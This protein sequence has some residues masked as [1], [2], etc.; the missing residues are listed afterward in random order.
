MPVAIAMPKLGL[1]M[2]EGT[3]L[4]WHAELGERVEKGQV[5]LLIESDKAETEI[6]APADGV[7]RHIYVDPDETVPCGT[8]LAVLTGSA[9]DEFDADAFRASEEVA[10]EVAP[11]AVAPAPRAAPARAA[12][13]PREAEIGRAHL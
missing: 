1:K 10:T 5:V 9:D 6:E 7:L 8:F 4:E 3:V 12:P 2:E 11:A 13:A